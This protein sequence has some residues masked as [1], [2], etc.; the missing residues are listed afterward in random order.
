MSL[1]KTDATSTCTWPCSVLPRWHRV[2]KSCELC[3]SLNEGSRTQ[4]LPEEEMNEKKSVVLSHQGSQSKFRVLRVLV[5][6]CRG[7]NRKGHTNQHL[8]GCFT[9]AE[10]ALE[11][12]HLE[13]KKGNVLTHLN[14]A[15]NIRCITNKHG[16]LQ[17]Y[18]DTVT[19]KPF[20]HTHTHTHTQKKKKIIIII[21]I[22][23]HRCA[24]TTHTDINR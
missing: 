21:I 22:I 8:H 2:D 9:A 16:H 19:Y 17:P 3:H 1:G 18:T 15:H 4:V 13:P 5:W 7:K 24:V 11:S 20:T 14:R 10:P 6:V 12:Q 23:I